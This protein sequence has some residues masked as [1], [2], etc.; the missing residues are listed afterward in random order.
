MIK[1]LL[2]NVAEPKYRCYRGAFSNFLT[3]PPL[4]IP[5]LVALLPENIEI[6][7][8]ICDENISPAKFDKKYDVVAMS[9]MSVGANRAY[10]LADRY[11]QDGAYLLAG[12]Y[13]PTFCSSEVL[14]HFDSVIKGAAEISFPKF[15]NDY[16]N[17]NCEKIYDYQNVDLKDY[18]FPKRE[19]IPKRGYLNIPPIIANRGCKNACEFCAISA[20]NRGSSLRPVSNVIDELKT[21]KNKRIVFFDPNFFQQKE[22]ALEI[23][24]ALGKMKKL[25]GCNATI[26]L[27]KDDELLESA[28]KNGCRGVLL[29]LES[30][31]AESLKNARKAFNKPNKFKDAIAKIRSYKIFAHGCFVLGFDSDTKEDL[32]SLPEQVNYLGLDLARFAIL[33]P[34]PNSELYI[35]LEKE[36]R[37][38]TKNWLLYDQNHAVFMPKNMTPS[39][40]EEIYHYVWKETFT[41][42]KIIERTFKNNHS[43]IEKLMLMGANLGFKYVGSDAKEWQ[44][45]LG[46]K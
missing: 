33:T 18:K 25:W 36:D 1:L 41:I 39:E 40:L 37:I 3:Y 22:Y 14:E 26:M 20:L 21:L 13:H 10:M 11:K 28:S 19:V 8:E 27:A 45:C 17:N 12:G 2:I 16:I 6:E 46:D 24:E 44:K 34:M 9:F 29:G 7:Y 4:T 15:F 43:I 23:M 42:G 32:K 38:I 5:Y 35:R 31:S 30:L